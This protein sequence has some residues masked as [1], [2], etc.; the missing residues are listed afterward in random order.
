MSVQSSLLTTHI[1][2]HTDGACRGNPGLGG[3]GAIIQF[4]SNKTR[5]ERVELSR[6][7]PNVTTNNRMELLAALCSLRFIRVHKGL[8]SDTPITLLSDSQYLV[9]GL[10]DWIVNW[11]KNGWRNASKKPVENKDLWLQLDEYASQF[12]K[13]SFKWVCGH[14]GDPDN[15]AADALANAAI[16]DRH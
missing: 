1:T 2:I 4:W 6:S 10:T 9:K 14:N 16:P 11:K 13:L 8:D 12:S 5:M 3:I 7:E 15:E